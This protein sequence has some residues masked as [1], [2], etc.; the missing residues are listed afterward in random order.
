M[1]VRKPRTGSSTN[2]SAITPGI[3]RV[4]E[5]VVLGVTLTDTLSFRPHVDRIVARTVQTS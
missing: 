3:G 2:P 1:I 4:R 5:M